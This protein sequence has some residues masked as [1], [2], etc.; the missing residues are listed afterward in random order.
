MSYGNVYIERDIRD[1][2]EEGKLKTKI[3]EIIGKRIHARYSD[4][5][6]SRGKIIAKKLYEGKNTSEKD[7]AR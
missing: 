5:S 4:I 1:L 3:I 2:K 7:W 6:V